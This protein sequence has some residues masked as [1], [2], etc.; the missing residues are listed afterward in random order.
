MLKMRRICVGFPQAG[1]G[2][3]LW[4]AA[5]E[6]CLCVRN[7]RRHLSRVLRINLFQ[8]EVTPLGHQSHRQIP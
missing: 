7:R 4:G 6:T 1:C 2:K 3:E 5:R 8:T